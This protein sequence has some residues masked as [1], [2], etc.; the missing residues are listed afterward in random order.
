[1]IPSSSSSSTP[2]TA[3][4]AKESTSQLKLILIL[5]SLS[6]LGPLSIDMYLPAFPALAES[7]GTSVASVQLTLATYLAGLAFGQIVYG[8]LSDRFGRRVPLMAGLGLYAAASLA[9]ALAPSL[10]L[11]AIAR[12]VQ[13][14]GGCAGMVVSRAVVRDRFGPAD[15]ARI[16][17]SLMLVMGAAPIL[18]PLIGAQVLLFA[19]WRAIFGVLFLASAAVVTN[20]ALS[21]PESLPVHARN[22]RGPRELA[23]DFAEALRN[24]RFVRLSVAGGTIQGAMF[25]YISGSPFVFIELFGI[26]ADQFGWI[27]GLNALGLIASSQI[28]RVLVPKFGPERI[29]RAASLGAATAFGVL[30]A[31]AAF[32]GSPLLMLAAIFCGLSTIGFVL[33]N[34]TALAMAPWERKAGVASATL[35]T[36]QS[37]CGALAAAAVGVLAN[38]TAMPMAGVMFV[39]AVA[40]WVLVGRGKRAEGAVAASVAV[41]GPA[42]A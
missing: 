7:L 26:P 38:G 11:L 33:P 9:C 3:S 29:L 42:D 32:G 31:A 15:S 37:T 5:G 34:A 25:A 41:G 20:I 17:S 4:Q 35:G 2:S 16:Y 18:A 22:R 36:L 39:C 10:P 6:A 28:N 23:G 27:F 8:P 1:M 30:A 24:R 13:A 21:L 14:L 40:G 19:G 12:F